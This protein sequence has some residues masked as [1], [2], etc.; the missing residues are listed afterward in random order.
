[1]EGAGDN[2]R[3]PSQSCFLCVLFVS[4]TFA[5]DQGYLKNSFKMDLMQWT[6]KVSVSKYI[7]VVSVKVV[8]SG[9]QLINLFEVV[10]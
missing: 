2:V 10:D 8:Y 7:R 6:M 5:K 4:C 3:Y 9:W 1:M